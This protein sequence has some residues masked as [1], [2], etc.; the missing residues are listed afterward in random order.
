MSSLFN[1]LY[2]FS[3]T[4]GPFLIVFGNIFCWHLDCVY[5]LLASRNAY[6]VGGSY[7]LYYWSNICQENECNLNNKNLLS[8]RSHINGRAGNWF[9]INYMGSK[10]PKGFNP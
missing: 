2:F 4:V 8:I 3:F 1:Y 5:M 7:D 10:N 9:K 6:P